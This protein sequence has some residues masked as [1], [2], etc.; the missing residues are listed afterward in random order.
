MRDNINHSGDYNDNITTC[1]ASDVLKYKTGWCYSKSHLLASLLRSNGI[2]TGFCYQK[3]SYEK[4]K[5]DI[6][7]LHGLNAIYLKDFGW[8]KVDARGNKK[9]IDAQFNPPLE[10]LAFELKENEFDLPKIYDEPLNIIIQALEKHITY[11]EMID[12][13]PDIEPNDVI[14]LSKEV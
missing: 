7:F 10:K 8:Y 2:P 6:Y 3:L 4:D 13:M 9:G 14:M 1:K 11:K 5:K 12:N